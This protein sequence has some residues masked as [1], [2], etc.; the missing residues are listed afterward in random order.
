MHIYIHIYIYVIASKK[1]CIVSKSDYAKIDFP[2]GPWDYHGAGSA[3]AA[4]ASKGTPLGRF[5]Q[6]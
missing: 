6:K 2:V 5:I 1:E 3:K 4:A